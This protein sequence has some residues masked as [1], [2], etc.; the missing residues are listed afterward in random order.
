V[1]GLKEIWFEFEFKR[2][3]EK[4]L[5]KK[6]KKEKSL[7]PFLAQWPISHTP[8]QPM[9]PPSSFSFLSFR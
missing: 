1:K 2:M 3:F 5:K 4:G 8:R 6:I 9:P 7:P